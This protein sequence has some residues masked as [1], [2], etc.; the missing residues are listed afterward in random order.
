MAF[1]VCPLH[2]LRDLPPDIHVPFGDDFELREL[3]HWVKSESMI[4]NM[5]WTDQQSLAQ[6]RYAFCSDYEASAM[7]ELDPASTP[8]E[9]RSIQKRKFDSL[10]F[11]NL[12]LWIA[13]PSAV[14]FTNVFS[15]LHW[16]QGQ[17]TRQP[18]GQ[19]IIQNIERQ[20]P[21]HCHPA[22]E[23]NSVEAGQVAQAGRLHT[24]LLTIPKGNTVWQAMRMFWA[25]LSSY[26]PDIRYS[27]FWVGLEA[28]FGPDGN[29]GEIT[30]KLAQRTAFFVSDAPQ[31][32]REIFSKAKNCYAMRSK[33]VHGRWKYDPLIDL[34]MTDTEMIVRRVCTRLLGDGQMLDTFMS[35]KRDVFLEEWVFSR[36][37]D[38]PPFPSP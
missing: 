2:N 8:A 33:I 25:A 28:L 24:V 23:N 18:Q 4:K 35:K 17:A 29:T 14:C 15:G 10:L 27:L 31:T 16:G 19:P 30:Y 9:P 6:D 36:S 26:A 3:P 37:A 1:T 38:P 21:M 13:R 32:A 7:G 22:D 20:N 5:S 34:T 12:A 11:A